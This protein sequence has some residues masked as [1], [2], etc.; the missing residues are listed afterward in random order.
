MQYTPAAVRS[1][2]LADLPLTTTFLPLSLTRKS[3][4]VDHLSAVYSSLPNQ[5]SETSLVSC[6]NWAI[7]GT[8][9]KGRPSTS[10]AMSVPFRANMSVNACAT[11]L[12]PPAALPPSQITASV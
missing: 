11:G 10:S 8:P 9:R 4:A 6:R 2:A 5:S 7:I 3:P 12:T 1:G